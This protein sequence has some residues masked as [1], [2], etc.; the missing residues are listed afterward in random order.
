[1]ANLVQPITNREQPGRACGAPLLTVRSLL[2]VPPEPHAGGRAVRGCAG[3]VR[4]AE[5][6]ACDGPTGVRAFADDLHAAGHEVTT[7][8]LYGGRTL[9]TVEE[10]VAYAEEVGFG[11][12]IEAGVAAADGLPPDLVH[13]GFSLGVMP[14]QRLAQQRPGSRGALLYHSAIP[15]GEFGDR[16]PADVPLQMHI[17]VDDPW[18]DLPV[19][20][21]LADTTGAELF[22]Y[23]GDRH[24]FTDRS[25][26][27]HD[28]AAAALVLERTIAFLD[29]LV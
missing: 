18:E 25:L 29:R 17:A 9:A 15:S 13:A 23:D 10:G 20:R 26:P 3:G 7:P 5:V 27:D 11:R 12:L 6:W 16:W 2:T 19:M 21:E 28:P 4:R 14:A 24:L 22:T 8:D 1:V